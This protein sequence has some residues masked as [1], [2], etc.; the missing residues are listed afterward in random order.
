MAE[1]FLFSFNAVA[2]IVCQVL[3]G[4]F[5]KRIHLV[6]EPFFRDANKLVF[7]VFLPVLMF[8][9]IYNIQSL[10]DVDFGMVLFSVAGLLIL[11]VLGFLTISLFVKKRNQKGVVWQ[12]I[13][14]CNYA[15]IGIPLAEML[16][17]QKALP[18]ASVLAAVAVPIINVLGVV[19][20]SLYSE[21]EKTNWKKV[22]LRILKNPI[23][24][25]CAAGGVALLIR[26]LIP[27]DADG[28]RLFTISGNLPFL[29]KTV[30][31]VAKIASPL[32]LIAI[33]GQFAF[34]MDPDS[35]LLVGLGVLWKIA[36]APALM[37][38][39]AILLSQYT[40]LFDFGAEQYPA[41]IA[42]FGSPTAVASAVM[43]QE[44]GGDGKLARQLVVWSSIG[45]AFT[46]FIEVM[47]LRFLGLL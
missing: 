18:N 21:K 13:F 34:Q 2:P 27:L 22:V 11:F 26:S 37:L 41:L 5:L 16:G 14:R 19:V 25:G 35:K 1:I 28:V 32:A 23:I 29:Y 17:G 10:D 38:G 46:I 3:L 47:I 44:M 12:A 24:L 15:F 40:G 31:N 36:L 33:G 7:R 43:A 42:L 8:Y 30:E 6:E 4:Y 39:S 20:L 9:N 45:S